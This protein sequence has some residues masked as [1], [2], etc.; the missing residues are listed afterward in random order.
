MSNFDLSKIGWCE[1]QHVYYDEA[2]TCLCG[3]L[4]RCDELR[5]GE[6][7]LVRSGE[8]DFLLQCI[9]DYKHSGPPIKKH[10]MICG[11]CASQGTSYPMQFPLHGHCARKIENLLW[12]MS[13]EEQLKLYRA[14][15]ARRG[16]CIYNTN[17]WQSDSLCENKAISYSLCEIHIKILESPS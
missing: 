16:L 15:H 2:K 6:R 5:S 12:H 9:T 11:E 1:M 4:E 10:C 7:E 8:M 14:G 3:K 13:N 17:A